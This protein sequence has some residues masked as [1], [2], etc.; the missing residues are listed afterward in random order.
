MPRYAAERVLLASLE[1]VWAFVAEPYNLS[2]WWP[3]IS[4]VQPDQRGFAE[5]ARW[6]VQG[7]GYF[8]RPDAP[9]LLVVKEIRPMRRFAFELVRE[10]L[11][12]EVE[13]RVEDASRTAVTVAVSGR[14]LIGPRSRIAKDAVNRLYDLVQTAAEL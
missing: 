2:D 1:E 6:H 7:P 10:R 3:G 4:G 11:A 9:Q 14:F 13:L 12:A 8:R 5:G